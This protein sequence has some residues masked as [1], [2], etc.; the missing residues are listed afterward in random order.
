MKASGVEADLKYPD[1]NFGCHRNAND[2]SD[3]SLVRHSKCQDRN[4]IEE[5]LKGIAM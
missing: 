5:S 2:F 1:A 3:T 4:K